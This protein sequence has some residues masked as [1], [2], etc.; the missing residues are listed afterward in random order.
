MGAAGGAAMTRPSPCPAYLGFRP[1]TVGGR[2]MPHFVNLDALIRRE[3]F[4]IKGDDSPDS[5][6]RV[7]LSG[8]DL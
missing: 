5:G 4:D 2:A 3:D 6:L 1:V 7:V 8:P